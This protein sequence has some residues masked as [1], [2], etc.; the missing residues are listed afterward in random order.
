MIIDAHSH[1]YST[2]ESSYPSMPDAY[3]PP[4]GA[5]TIEHLKREMKAAGVD[6]AV[7]I[8][9]N[10]FYRWD[11]H[12]IRDTS[13]VSRDWA[14][15]VCNLDP[16]DPHSPDVLSAL[17]ERSNVKGLRSIWD[18]YVRPDPPGV[19]R[20]W[21]E[22]DRLGI[23]VNA[24]VPVQFGNELSTFLDDYQDL[25]V[26][27][28]HSLALKIG[29]LYD[30]TLSRILELARHPNL[31]AK[32][33]FLPWGSAEQSPFQDMH[34]ACKRIIDAYGPERCL[35]G[36]NF[37]TEL[38]APKATYAEHLRIFKQELGLSQAEQD[39][40]LGGTAERLWFGQTDDV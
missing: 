22:A 8:Q 7:L 21:T 14:V 33:T 29:P 12:F 4:L 1:P 10:S 11:N 20:L 18:V 30:V 34:D 25:R 27:L 5:G 35:W 6:R 37:P 3:R 2:D 40:V 15:G 36:S 31:Y 9:T 32:M 13:A 19:R 28:D 23:V 17:V 24:L 38:W 16:D 26:V 39:A